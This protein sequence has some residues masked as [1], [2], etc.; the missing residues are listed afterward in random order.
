VTSLKR[1]AALPDVPTL[2]ELGIK[3]QE[4]ETMQGVLA[5]AG[6]PKEIIALLQREIAAALEQPDVKDKVLALGF[7]PSGMSS[8]EFDAYIKSEIAKWRKV[9]ENA[10]IPKI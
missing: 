8:A 10:G 3:G 1:A 5:P 9:I 2:E 4:A 7:E 6:T